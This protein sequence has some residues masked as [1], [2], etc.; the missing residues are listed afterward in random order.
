MVSIIAPY[1]FQV[2]MLPCH[3]HTLLRIDSAF[4]RAYVR[5]D[6]HIFKLHHAGVGEE[7]GRV[8]ARDKWHRGHGCVTMFHKKVYKC[9]ADLVTGKL[10]NYTNWLNNQKSRT[11]AGSGLE[12]QTQSRRHRFIEQSQSGLRW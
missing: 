9:L 12:I 7:Q 2:V 6:K 11:F 5:S 3:T 10:M 1:I 8:S 4:I